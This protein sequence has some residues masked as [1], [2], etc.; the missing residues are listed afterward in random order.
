MANDESVDASLIFWLV[1]VRAN[2]VWSLSRVEFGFGKKT[3]CGRTTV[4]HFWPR[5]L[6]LSQHKGV[7]CSSVYETN[8]NTKRITPL[9]RFLAKIKSLD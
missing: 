4:V 2:V 8:K 3:H 6:L 1:E 9:I 5:K 7:P